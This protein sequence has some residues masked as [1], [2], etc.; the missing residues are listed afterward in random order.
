[1]K[2]FVRGPWLRHQRVDQ[3]VDERNQHFHLML[4]NAGLLCHIWQSS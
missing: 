4:P 2:C 1:M 3:A